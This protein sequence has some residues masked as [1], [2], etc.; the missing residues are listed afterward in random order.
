[1]SFRTIRLR[2]I[3][4]PAIVVAVWATVS[5]LTYGSTVLDSEA[6]RLRVAEMFVAAPEPGLFRAKI[7]F[8]TCQ[9]TG[10]T[11][12]SAADEETGF[13]SRAFARRAYSGNDLGAVAGSRGY[14][15]RELLLA[16]QLDPKLA[17]PLWHQRMTLL[18]PD[19]LYLKY[20]KVRYPVLQ[21]S[22][23]AYLL[24]VQSVAEVRGLL[25]WSAYGSALLLLC[26]TALLSRRALFVVAPVAV[27]AAAW[28]S[29]YLWS[30]VSN[31][32]TFVFALLSAAGLAL[33]LAR[34][35]ASWA[36]PVCFA[37]GLFMQF[38]WFMDA[39]QIML[40]TL[41]ALLLWFGGSWAGR[42]RRVLT[43][44]GAYL[45]GFALSFTAGFMVRTALART[46]SSPG[47]WVA[48]M[49]DNLVGKAGEYGRR[50]EYAD[51][52][53]RLGLDDWARFVEQT[54][55]HWEAALVLTAIFALAALGGF[56]LSRLARYRRGP[57]SWQ[58]VGFV[59]ALV[60]LCAVQFMAPEDIPHRSARYVFVPVSLM[61]GGGILASFLAWGYWKRRRSGHKRD[62]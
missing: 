44:C 30:D 21:S 14:Y 42:W 54:S 3:L 59:A 34:G 28:S 6:L 57:A 46:P 62:V 37:V 16:A 49:R 20:F 48:A 17:H 29:V 2:W 31:G 11:L 7:P 10:S 56:R 61:C 27:G 45:A 51:W 39:H 23:Y 32:F 25:L 40:F 24:R 52:P 1:M 38:L 53:A 58:D 47:D 15:C 50:A 8:E 13:W 26:A 43:G 9:V 4:Y 18:P 19:G 22:L 5:A 55:W 35:G 12:A 33:A 60:L 41:L 36:A